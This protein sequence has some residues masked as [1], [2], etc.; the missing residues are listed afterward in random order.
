MRAPAIP[1]AARANWV[2]CVVTAAIAA[3][4]MPTAANAAP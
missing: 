1:E 3:K 2:T 4:T